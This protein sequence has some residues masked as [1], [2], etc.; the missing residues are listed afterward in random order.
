MKLSALSRRSCLSAL[1][2]SGALCSSL[3]AQAPAVATGDTRT[4][5]EP[6]FPSTCQTLTASFHDV[7]EDV[8]AAVEAVSTELDQSRLQTALNAC[9]GTNQAVELSMDAA[10]NN[11]FLTGP[12]TIPT[13]V[14]LLV[15]PGVTLYF[16]R[17]AQHHHPVHHLRTN[18]SNTASCQNLI[19]ISTM[20]L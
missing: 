3:L 16:S 14:T 4:V 18:N 2:L 15:D 8:P 5:V 19:T 13:G 1:L 7:G 6:T 11:A 12:I 10:G 17:N 20:Q 9:Q